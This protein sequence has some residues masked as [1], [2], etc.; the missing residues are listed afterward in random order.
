LIPKNLP[1]ALNLVLHHPQSSTLELSKKQ[2][3]ILVKMKEDKKPTI[4]KNA[5]AIKILEMKLVRLLESNEGKQTEVS[6]EMSKLIDEIAGKKA[7]LTKVHLQ[8]VI[9]VQNILTKEQQEKVGAYINPI[10]K[11]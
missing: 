2:I 3:E 9:D 4:I 11:K 8:C 1:F 10:A 6:A 5:K 7:E